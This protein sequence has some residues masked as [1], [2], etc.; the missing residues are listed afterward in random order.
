MKLRFTPEALQHI[1]GIQFY[2]EPHSQQA[3]KRAAQKIYA[4]ADMLSA[5]PEIGR[6]G[7]VPG[8]YELAVP[9]LPY[10]LVHEL[11][12]AESEII[13]IAVFH[14]AQSRA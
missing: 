3:A 1:A 12:H 9:K 2:I 4:A 5:F 11:D 14:G 13:I 7:M 8:T 10:I 6:T